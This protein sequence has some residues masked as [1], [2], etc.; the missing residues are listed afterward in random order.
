[1]T[2]ELPRVLPKP[3][4]VAALNLPHINVKDSE[5]LITPEKS[6][7]TLKESSK[8]KN[9]E[10]ATPKL[11]S[12]SLTSGKEPTAMP[13]VESSTARRE[14]VDLIP[15]R[16]TTLDSDPILDVTPEKLKTALKSHDAVTNVKHQGQV[17]SSRVRF[18][19]PIKEALIEDSVESQKNPAHEQSILGH[20]NEPFRKRAALYAKRN[21]LA[22]I[23]NHCEDQTSSENTMTKFES[24]ASTN[25]ES[26]FFTSM[27]SDHSIS[28]CTTELGMNVD[29]V[30][31]TLP[32]VKLK[33]TERHPVA[34]LVTTKNRPANTKNRITVVK[35][36]ENQS[37]LID[38]ATRPN[39]IEVG[40]KGKSEETKR[41]FL[42]K[43]SSLLKHEHTV[44]YAVHDKVEN[45]LS[46]A[47][48]NSTLALGQK[49]QV[50]L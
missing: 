37:K 49:L 48:Y 26:S 46:T 5:L 14:Y 19:V 23:P 29:N 11:P 12:G 50:I 42:K 45:A 8:N 17:K 43:N 44:R 39:H 40:L 24:S 20:Q 1:M 41:Q 33:T 21:P 7:L 10:N 34:R 30:R 36:E 27:S 28:S 3:L 15:T 18:N 25:T 13:L 2:E 6:N 32:K 38:Q 16:L 31:T 22:D 35:S 4:R 47:A 9:D